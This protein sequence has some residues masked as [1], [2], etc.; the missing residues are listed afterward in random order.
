[1]QGGTHIIL[2]CLDLWHQFC[3]SIHNGNHILQVS[4]AQEVVFSSITK[5]FQFGSAKIHG[6]DQQYFQP[7]L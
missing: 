6:I 4:T 1:V 3:S 7:W 5:G 2:G